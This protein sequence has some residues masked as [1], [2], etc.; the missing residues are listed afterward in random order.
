MRTVETSSDFDL[1]G[2]QLF[3]AVNFARFGFDSRLKLFDHVR[4]ET[5]EAGGMFVADRGRW[6]MTRDSLPG[7]VAVKALGV[8]RRALYVETAPLATQQVN[9]ALTEKN[10]AARYDESMHSFV[11]FSGRVLLTVTDAEVSPDFMPRALWTIFW[12]SLRVADLELALKIADAVYAKSAWQVAPEHGD[13]LV[14][15]RATGDLRVELAQMMVQ[16]LAREQRPLLSLEPRAQHIQSMRLEMR[17]IL[18]LERSL[19]NAGPEALEEYAKRDL[20][21]EGQR[22]TMQILVFVLAGRIK[23]EINQRLSWKQAR[24][25]A[26]G[27]IFRT[28]A[29]V[30]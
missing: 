4:D 25:A 30:P 19:L 17:P 18:H 23:R 29:S 12:S 15:T 11:T 5:L 2:G 27:M 10:V 20:S 14:A 13:L 3:E 6:F 7:D 8:D 24:R 26:H 21:P 28:S 1:L 22:R 16:M 9:E